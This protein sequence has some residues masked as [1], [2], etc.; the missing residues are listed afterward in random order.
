MVD[1]KMD[2][3]DTEFITNGGSMYDYRYQPMINIIPCFSA[4]YCVVPFIYLFGAI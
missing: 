3:V 1:E 4:I 2:L